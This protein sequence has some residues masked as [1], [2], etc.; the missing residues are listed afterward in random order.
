M[1]RIEIERIE[2]YDAV[3]GEVTVREIEIEV[4]T[5]DELIADKE[6]ELLKV[7]AEIQALK[8][9]LNQ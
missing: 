2:T 4:P 3:T 1:P 7:Y 8:T 6:A 5:D 9:S